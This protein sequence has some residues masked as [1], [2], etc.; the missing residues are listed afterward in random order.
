MENIYSSFLNAENDCDTAIRLDNALAKAYF[1]R[2]LARQGLNRYKLALKDFQKASSLLP[3]NK[4]IDEAIISL[5]NF[6]DS[7]KNVE[8]FPIE[9]GD[10]FKSKIPLQEIS[11]NY[12]LDNQ[13]KEVQLSQNLRDLSLYPKP[14]NFGDFEL[15]WR[16]INDLNLKVNFLN[17]LDLNTFHKIFEYPVEANII[18]DMFNTLLHSSNY[19]HIY[20]ILVAVTR[21][22]RFDCVI[23][24]LS[25]KVKEG[26]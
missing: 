18:F 3:N 5:K 10:Q 19:L 20:Q 4:E 21:N 7:N 1:R 15:I 22:P 11:I 26:L 8:I 24:F 17:N 14:T 25:D 9:K 12:D 6:L 23:W 2:G 13:S 16:E